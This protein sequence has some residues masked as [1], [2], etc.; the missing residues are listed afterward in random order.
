LLSGCL[1]SWRIEADQ[2]TRGGASSSAATVEECRNEC[3]YNGSCTAVDWHTTASAG[4]RCW[5]H[6]SWTQGSPG[7][8]QG[9]HRHIIS[10]KC[11]QKLPSAHAELADYFIFSSEQHTKS[12][13]NNWTI[14]LT[15]TSVSSSGAVVAVLASSMP[16]TRTLLNSTAALSLTVTLKC[17]V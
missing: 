8:G 6:G 10:R 17:N 15:L 1:P 12:N 16:T 3:M 4:Q 13:T 2:F 7:R 9:M 5:L 11:G 14:R